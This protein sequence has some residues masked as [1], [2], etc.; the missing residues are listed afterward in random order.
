MKGGSGGG[1][2]PRGML[3]SLS[4]EDLP[5]SRV[6]IIRNDLHHPLTLVKGGCDR[7]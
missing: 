4:L 2:H 7:R 1:N 5:L 6:L 3:D